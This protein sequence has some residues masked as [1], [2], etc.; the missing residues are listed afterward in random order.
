MI[1]P[2][3]MTDQKQSGTKKALL[4][5][6]RQQLMAHEQH[7][8]CDLDIGCRNWAWECPSQSLLASHWP[9]RCFPGS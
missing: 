3:I 5:Y 9:Q 7:T 2:K 1:H 8:G 6:Y 4:T